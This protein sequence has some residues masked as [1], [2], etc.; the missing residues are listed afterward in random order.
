ME[1]AFLAD[2]ERDWEGKAMNG[3]E[4]PA[5][6]RASLYRPEQ[7]RE[8]EGCQGKEEMTLSVGPENC[9]RTD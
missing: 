1:P 7:T 6:T 4:S 8:E 2:G 3:G 9:Q 5:F